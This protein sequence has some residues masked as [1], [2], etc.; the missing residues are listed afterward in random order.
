MNTNNKYKYPCPCC[1]HLTFEKEPGSLEICL[2]CLWQ[3]DC[4][5]LK[6]PYEACGPNKVSLVTAQKNYIYFGVK[7]KRL[8]QLIKKESKTVEFKLEKEWRLI[9]TEHDIFSAS[10][11][12]ERPEN[13]TDLYYWRAT[14]WLK[15]I[16]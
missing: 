8:L 16:S 9:D 10:D 4:I 7:E 5:S 15:D 14:Y 12:L 2:K 11:T 3:D 6:F 1:G 13:Y